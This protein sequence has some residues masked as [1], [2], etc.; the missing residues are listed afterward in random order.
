MCRLFAFVSP[1]SST[2]RRELGD[3]G[4]ESLVSLA[5][6]HGDGWGWAGV[7]HAGDSPV[8]HKSARSAVTDPGFE[9]AMTTPAHSAM[10]HLRWATSGIPIA[11]HNA[12]PFQRGDLAFE[13]NGALKPIAQLRALLSPEAL[14]GME[15]ETDSEMYFTLIREQLA[16]GLPLHEATVQVVR[17]LREVFPLASLNAIL[18]DREQMIVVRASAHSI[19]SDRSLDEIALHAHL[20]DEHNEDYFALR[21]KRQPDGTIVIGSTGVAEFDWEPLP[22][23]SVT[24]IR[25]GDRTGSTIALHPEHG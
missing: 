25:L 15:G 20:P 16:L 8:V 5:R 3:P 9:A 14:A 4:M 10:V 22:P 2:V 17:R 1:A 18:L 21:W 11:D 6:L 12:H 24:A 19:L 23:E 13:H 7:E